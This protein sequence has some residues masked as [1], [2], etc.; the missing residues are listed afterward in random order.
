MLCVCACAPLHQANNLTI[1]LQ[2]PVPSLP[3]FALVTTHGYVIWCCFCL[4]PLTCQQLVLWCVVVCCFLFDLWSSYYNFGWNERNFR[5]GTCLYW[6]TWAPLWHQLDL[7]S[8]VHI[9]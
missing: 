3:V 1:C 9:S 4:R 8:S 2:D 7:P 5:F 6:P